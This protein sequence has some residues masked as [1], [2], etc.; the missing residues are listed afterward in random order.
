MADLPSE[1][2][3]INPPF[4]YVLLDVFGPWMVK[5]R[6]NG[7][8]Q[9]HHRVK[10]I[11]YHTSIAKVRLWHKPCGVSKALGLNKLQQDKRVLRYLSEQNCFWE[12]NP[13]H[14]LHREAIINAR[15]HIPVSTDQQSAFIL[16]LAML[17]TQKGEVPSPPGDSD[18]DLLLN[19]WRQVQALANEFWLRW[20]RE[21]LPTLQSHRKWN[22]MRRNLQEGDT[23]L[24]KDNQLLVIHGQWQWSFLL[25][26]AKMENY[27]QL[28]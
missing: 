27:E 13:L 22:E 7:G 12:F 24:L 26:I 15:P 16:N 20:K 18:R 6:R 19:Q 23:V 3:K 11:L 4:T 28:I 21:Y 2:L 5:E 9:L 17:L 25:S 10:T 14:Y 1:C 8:F